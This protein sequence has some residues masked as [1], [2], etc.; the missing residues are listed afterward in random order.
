MTCPDCYGT[1]AAEDYDPVMP[2]ETCNGEGVIYGDAET[3]Q[4]D[5]IYRDS[6]DL[7]PS[8]TGAGLS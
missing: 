1:G 3:D 4:R 5:R 7:A 8:D 2:C 6:V